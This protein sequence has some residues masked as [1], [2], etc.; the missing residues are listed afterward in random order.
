MEEILCASSELRK[1]GE[2]SRQGKEQV[3]VMAV[4]EVM[5]AAN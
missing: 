3:S 5:A 1:G 4:C 2:S